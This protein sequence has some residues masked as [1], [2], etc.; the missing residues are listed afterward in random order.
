VDTW[1]Y[2]GR[3]W[4]FDIVLSNPGAAREYRLPFVSYAAAVG[5]TRH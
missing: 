5:C 1:F 2:L 3:R 4:A